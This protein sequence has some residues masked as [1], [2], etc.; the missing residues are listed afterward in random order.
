MEETFKMTDR[1]SILRDGQYQGTVATA[2]TNEESVT[3]RMIGRNLDLSRNA[4]HHEM[5]DVALE[6][7]GLYCGKLYQDIDFTVR[8]GEVRRAGGQRDYLANFLNAAA[9]RSWSLA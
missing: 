2:G 8:R 1:I 7:R 4:S 6:V 9:S 3:Q 5:G